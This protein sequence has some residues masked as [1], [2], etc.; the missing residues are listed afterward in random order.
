MKN[1]ILFLICFFCY[2]SAFSQEKEKSNDVNRHFDASLFPKG[3]SNIN[4]Y[5]KSSCDRCENIVKMLKND[6]IKFHEFDLSDP[7][8]QSELDVKVY[9][10]IPYKD[11]GITTGYPVF[12]IDTIVFFH[13]DNHV[14]FT[15]DLI[16]YLKSFKQNAE[17]K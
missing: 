9:N 8:I 13:I 4:V 15:N 3:I 2:L 12:E 5:I 14:A 16:S 11:L 1:K 17:K 10:T 6:S 7:K